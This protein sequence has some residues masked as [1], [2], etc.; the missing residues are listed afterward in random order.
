MRIRLELASDSVRRAMECHD[1]LVAAAIV[2]L[3]ISLQSGGLLLLANPVIG[4]GDARDADHYVRNARQILPEDV[5]GAC[6]GYQR[7]VKAKGRDKLGCQA[8]TVIQTSHELAFGFSG[9]D[10]DWTSCD[11]PEYPESK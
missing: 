3:V 11:L 5:E 2:S 9:G 8:G 6:P 4:G 1:R 10:V 7:G